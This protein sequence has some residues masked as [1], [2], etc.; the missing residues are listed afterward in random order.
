M[1][2]LYSDKLRI[3]KGLQVSLGKGPALVMVLLSGYSIKDIDDLALAAGGF[4]YD[5]WSAAY[6]TAP[7]NS[8]LRIDILPRMELAM[9]SARQDSANISEAEI[10]NLKMALVR[11]TYNRVPADSITAQR[12][13]T[14][15]EAEAESADD[16]VWLF[17]V[18]TK[19]EP[20]GRRET[21]DK[22]K[23]V[24]GST[25]DHWA[26]LLRVGEKNPFLEEILAEMSARAGTAM[27]WYRIWILSIELGEND[28]IHTKAGENHE[29]SSDFEMVISCLGGMDDTPWA[30]KLLAEML[31]RKISTPEQADSAWRA[32]RG[33][34][35]LQ[36]R[37]IDLLKQMKAEFGAWQALAAN[38]SN[39]A[40]RL[41]AI[42]TMALAAKE[43]AEPSQAIS[44]W[45]LTYDEARKSPAYEDI[46]AQ[47]ADEICKLA[48][49]LDDQT[50]PPE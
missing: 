46:L 5:D 15:A 11:E 29:K 22:L 13:F 39:S 2:R 14:R 50:R 1:K 25:Y 43:T 35:R 48:D 30:E 20:E 18:Q 44:R 8:P 24:E 10:N 41:I 34:P 31:V 12:L 47:A 3:F 36:I 9:Q 4:S 26:N 40:M 45:N 17:H 38:N 27:Q 6:K 42:E 23:A 16:L 32:L 33:N 19:R 37:V 49:A 28:P 21:L 7:E